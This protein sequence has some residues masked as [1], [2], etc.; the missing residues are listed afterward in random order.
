MVEGAGG[1]QRFSVVHGPHRCAS[2]ASSTCPQPA[3]RAAPSPPVLACEPLRTPAAARSDRPAS[4][5]A[6]RYAP[7]QRQARLVE[8]LGGLQIAQRGGRFLHP[9]QAHFSPESR[10]PFQAHTSLKETTTDEPSAIVVSGAFVK[11]ALIGFMRSSAA[12]ALTEHPPAFAHIANGSQH[13][14][15]SASR[16]RASLPLP[17]ARTSP[18]LR[19]SKPCPRHCFEQVRPMLTVPA[20]AEQAT[21]INHHR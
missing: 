3:G 13:R 9:S 6:S 16:M 18:S 5:G 20:T 14:S 10:D 12:E 4:G 1:G 15:V 8:F 21:S 7:E 11:L 19:G 2:G 17:V